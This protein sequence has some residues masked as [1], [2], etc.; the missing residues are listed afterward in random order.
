MK[1]SKSKHFYQNGNF[2][3]W[4]SDFCEKWRQKFPIFLIKGIKKIDKNV[5]E[6]L[7]DIDFGVENIN[8]V[9]LCN[10]RAKAADG[11]YEIHGSFKFE[12][13]GDNK[14]MTKSNIFHFLRFILTKRSLIAIIQWQSI[15]LFLKAVLFAQPITR[16]NWQ[17][18]FSLAHD[19]EST[20][21]CLDPCLS[22]IWKHAGDYLQGGERLR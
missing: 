19:Y 11:F 1:L 15:T 18:R 8:E 16:S 22:L 4:C 21:R 13:I 14:L 12:W 2:W 10:M 7:I 5:Y 9:L 6:H 3:P 17:N 20:A